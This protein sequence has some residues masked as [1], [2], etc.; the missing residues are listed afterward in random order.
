VRSP[1]TYVRDSGLLHALLGL[2]DK[3]ALLGHPILGPSWEGYLIENLIALA[4]ERVEP[5]FYRTAGGA[6]IDP[7]PEV[8]GGERVGDRGQA[9][10]LSSTHSW[11]AIGDEDLGPERSFIVYPGENRYRLGEDIEVVNLPDLAADLNVP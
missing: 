8:A 2:G 6:K 11:Y 4:P 7:G 1:R 3:E 5:S 10:A 9:L